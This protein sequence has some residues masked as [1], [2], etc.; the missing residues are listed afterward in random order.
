MPHIPR[1]ICGECN[2][3]MR[4]VKSG[5]D[6]EMLLEDGAPYYK[7]Q[8]DRHECSGRMWNTGSNVPR[9]TPR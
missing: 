3:E 4:C 8:V 1:A 6:I 2:I 5:V 9:A 7:I